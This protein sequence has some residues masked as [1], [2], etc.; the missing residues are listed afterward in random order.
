MDVKMKNR[1]N[2]MKNRRHD[3]FLRRVDVIPERVMKPAGDRVSEQQ[4]LTDLNEP[5]RFGGGEGGGGGVVGNFTPFSPSPP[6]FSPSSSS[7]SKSR[8]FGGQHQPTLPASASSPSSP[9]INIEG[10]G[11][12]LVVEVGVVG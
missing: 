6:T 9:E 11:G 5:A 1:K 7:S 3:R 12:G 10:S 2:M 4:T 8:G